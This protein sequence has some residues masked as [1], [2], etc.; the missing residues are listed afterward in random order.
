MQPSKSNT[1][2]LNPIQHSN[3]KVRERAGAE[4]TLTVCKQNGDM[5][6]ERKNPLP[7]LTVKTINCNAM[8]I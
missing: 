4:R 5:T 7:P 8:L 2:L 6:E 3:I 1:F